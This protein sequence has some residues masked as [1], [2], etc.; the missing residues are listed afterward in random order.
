VKIGVLLPSQFTDSGD[1]LADARALDAAGVDSLW[2]AADGFDP[3]LVLAAIAT[4]T[5]RARLAVA[6]SSREGDAPDGLA[7]RLTTLDRLSRGRLLT[8]VRAAD[9]P[10]GTEALVGHVR[11]SVA[12]PV[13]LNAV[14]N[15]QAV[16]AARLADG[17]VSALEPADCHASFDHAR[18]C[19][20]RER[21]TAPFEMWAQ[22]PPPRGRE[23]WR[24]LLKEAE[25]AGATGLI[26]PA[27]PRLLDLLRNADEEDDRSD[28]TLAQ[29]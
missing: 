10:A 21:R 26:V 3:W 6:L 12:T 22:S 23:H 19:R 8:T 24:A 1:Y 4:V 2:L 13:L 17:M 9:E 28:L 29:G 25:A 27:D 20:E 11:R 18:V 15:G 14:G 16:V 7:R 5:G